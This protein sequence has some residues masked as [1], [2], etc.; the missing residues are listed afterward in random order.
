M[1]NLLVFLAELVG[2]CIAIA[3]LF[4]CILWLTIMLLGIWNELVPSKAERLNRKLRKQRVKANKARL[5]GRP[6]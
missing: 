3:F 4:C 5:A 6:K 2:I 1:L